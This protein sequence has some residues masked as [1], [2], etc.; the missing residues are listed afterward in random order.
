VSLEEAS[1]IIRHLNFSLVKHWAEWWLTLCWTPNF[2]DLGDDKYVLF[3][4]N[5]FLVICFEEIVISR[6]RVSSPW[7][8]WEAR[9][10]FTYY[11]LSY[12]CSH[13]SGN[14][15]PGPLS[16]EVTKWQQVLHSLDIA[17]VHDVIDEPSWAFADF[18]KAVTLCNNLCLTKYLLFHNFVLC[19]YNDFNKTNQKLIFIPFQRILWSWI[20]LFPHFCPKCIFQRALSAC[21]EQI[22]DNAFL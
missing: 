18:S 7:V 20:F 13:D 3:Y 6:N 11:T 17:V 10:T 5:A 19:P 1:D 22:Y 12:L 8:D 9:N 14:I 16:I 2:G 4:V 15:S 21:W